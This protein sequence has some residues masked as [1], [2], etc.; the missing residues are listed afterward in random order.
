MQNND[1]Q[2]TYFIYV[3]S[4]ARRCRSPRNSTITFIRKQTVSATRS[5]STAGTCALTASSRSATVT[6]SAVNTMRQAISLLWISL[7]LMATAPSAITFLTTASRWM[8]SS[9]IVCYWNSSLPV[10]VNSTR[11]LIPLF[12]FGRITRR[13]S[14]T[15]PLQEISDACR[16]PSQIR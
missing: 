5:R 12:S 2:K 8:K 10:C 7:S 9:P 15:A 1:N 6:A 3:R 13:A 14:P 16:R 4:T 11:R